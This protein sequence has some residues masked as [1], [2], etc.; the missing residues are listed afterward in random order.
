M[1]GLVDAELRDDRRVVRFWELQVG[2]KRAGFVRQGLVVN[3]RVVKE[4]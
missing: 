1:S 3:L 4:L 2:S